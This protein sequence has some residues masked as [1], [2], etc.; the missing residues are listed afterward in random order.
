MSAIKC[1][2]CKKTMTEQELIENEDCCIDCQVQICLETSTGKPLISLQAFNET[3]R[4]KFDLS[5]KPI[6]NGIAC[7]ECGTEL[8][9]SSP[10]ITLNSLPPKKN[11]HCPQCGWESYRVA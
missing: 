8:L 5:N 4:Q 6:P 1:W 3:N 11:V 2:N 7:P 10:L 9:D